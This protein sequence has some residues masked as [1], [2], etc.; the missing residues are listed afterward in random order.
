MH[1]FVLF[2]FGNSLL[3]QSNPRDAKQINHWKPR[4]VFFRVRDNYQDRLFCQALAEPGDRTNRGSVFVTP[5]YLY[6]LA[7]CFSEDSELSDN[8]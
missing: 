6:I 3:L 4:K 5:V 1:Y 2:L 8:L 7:A